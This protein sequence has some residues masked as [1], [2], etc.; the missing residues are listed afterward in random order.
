MRNRWTLVAVLAVVLVVGQGLVATPAA[1][2]QCT[3]SE[4]CVTVGV[5]GKGA[6]AGG[7]IGAEIGFLIPALIVSA[8]GRDLDEA[9]AYIIFPLVF[10][11]GGAIGGFYGFEEPNLTEVAVAMLAVGMALIVPTFVGVLALTSYAPGPDDGRGA[12]GDE[13]IEDSEGSGTEG[14]DDQESAAASAMRRMLAGGPGLVRI[15]EHGRLLLG[16][17]MVHSTP[18]Y[19]REEVA[20]M[21][22]TQQVDVNIPLIS[23]TF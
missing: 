13:D 19:T 5:D 3:A 14:S 15:D 21:R 4:T 22:L 23:G 9:W 1:M 16:V 11:A 8:G 10:G 12:S 7:I 18:T 20:R 17:P 2:A 6:L